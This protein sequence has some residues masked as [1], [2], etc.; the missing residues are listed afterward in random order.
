M[1]ALTQTRPLGFHCSA[2]PEPDYWG[3]PYLVPVRLK[4]TDGIG[5]LFEYVVTLKTSESYR[6]RS[7]DPANVDLDKLLGVEATAYVQVRGKY[8]FVPGMPGNTGAG[9][10]GGHTREISGII[11]AARIAGSDGRSIVY[12]LTLRPA[13]YLAT[14]NLN[15]RGFYGLDVIAITREVMHAYPLQVEYRI[16]GPAGSGNGYYPTRDYQRQAFESDYTFLRRLCV[17]AD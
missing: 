3:V 11:A 6:G 13:L 2:L 5:E 16:G 10:V 15:S 4:G 14:Q 1:T 12:E 9:N 8:E 7:A 17:N